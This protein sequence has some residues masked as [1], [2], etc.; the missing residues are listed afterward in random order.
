MRASGILQ[1][2]YADRIEAV[3]VTNCDEALAVG[4]KIVLFLCEME[5]VKAELRMGSHGELGTETLDSEDAYVCF[6]AR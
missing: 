5:R 3:M 1:Q 2:R 6:E 4:G